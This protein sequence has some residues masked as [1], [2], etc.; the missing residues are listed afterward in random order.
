MPEEEDFHFAKVKY[1]FDL[2]EK[3][4]RVVE[5][6]DERYDALQVGKAGKAKRGKK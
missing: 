1:A 3:G 4:C 5:K 6:G 2:H